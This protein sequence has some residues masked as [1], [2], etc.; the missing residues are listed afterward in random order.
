MRIPVRH[1]HVEAPRLRLREAGR[2]HIVDYTT[3]ATASSPR[4]AVR[5]RRYRP[6]GDRTDLGDSEGQGAGEYEYSIHLKEMEI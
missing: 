4:D 5:S 2:L 6:L 1:V 3:G